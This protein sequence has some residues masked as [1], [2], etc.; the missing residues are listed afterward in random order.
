MKEAINT[1][2]VV[3]TLLLSITWNHCHCVGGRLVAKPF[4]RT[5]RERERTV[6]F[7]ILKVWLAI[8]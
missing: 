4:L 8:F 1:A 2:D 7:I 6:P 5:R 3:S